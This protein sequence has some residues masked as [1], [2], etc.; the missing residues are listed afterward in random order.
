MLPVKLLDVQPHHFVLDA[1]ASPGS[2]TTQILDALHTNESGEYIRNP[3]GIVFANDANRGRCGILYNALNEF[4]S[5]SFVISSIFAQRFPDLTTSL[6]SKLKFD[7]ILCDVPCSGDGI[8]KKARDQW[9]SWEEI[10]GRKQHEI[11]CHILNRAY[12]LLK[13]GGIMVY[14]TCSLNPFENEAVVAQCLKRFP[15]R[16][17]IVRVE[18]PGLKYRPGLTTWVGDGARTD[19]PDENLGLQNC[20]RIM[21]QDTNACGFFTCVL[22]KL[23]NPSRGNFPKPQTPKVVPDPFQALYGDENQSFQFN[24]DK[25]NTE[26]GKILK[27]KRRGRPQM[28]AEFTHLQRILDSP[29]MYIEESLREAFGLDDF[30]FNRLVHRGNSIEDPIF[31]THPIASDLLQH[32]LNR[33]LCLQYMGARAF[34]FREGQWEISQY[35]VCELLPFLTKR[36]IS[37]SH[38]EF[39]Q[40]IHFQDVP[41]DIRWTGSIIFK[42]KDDVFWSRDRRFQAISAW[43]TEDGKIELLLDQKQLTYL[44]FHSDEFRV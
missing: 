29:Q 9:A 26:Y 5:S 22:R 14:S 24:Y 6:Y 10:Y 38:A 34:Y 43:R 39:R 15:G 18:I 42:L 20:I 3:P 25:P 16:L 31:L 17:E 11:Q 13:T 37:I 41:L 19:P 30:D 40:L 28:P 27:G 1:C 21:P 4:G 23:P 12:T 44:R 36:V 8:M 32:T 33:R 2:K 7:R 35:S